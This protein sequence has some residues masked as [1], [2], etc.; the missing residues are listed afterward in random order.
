MKLAAAPE[1][2]PV[3][4]EATTLY[5]AKNPPKREYVAKIESIPVVGVEIRKDRTAPFEAPSRRRDIA[6][7]I[8]EQEQS[9]SGIP[10]KEALTTAKKLFCPRWR[11]MVFVSIK[12][13]N[14]PAKRNPNNK[15][16]DISPNRKH[17][18]FI[19]PINVVIRKFFISQVTGFRV[20]GS[21]FRVQG[22]RFRG[23]GPGSRVPVGGGSAFG[24][25]P[26]T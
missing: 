6:A 22:S 1:S 5:I 7:G 24:G 18:S 9:G 25:K 4:K 23:Q 3:T 26:V 15:Y 13:C 14:I 12:I 20:Q 11:L 16:G 8:T 10:N 19:T 2:T 17:A 21:G